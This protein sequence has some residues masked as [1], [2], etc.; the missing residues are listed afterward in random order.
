MTTLPAA[1]RRAFYA[2]LLAALVLP[3]AALA[4]SDDS[5]AIRALLQERD[6]EIKALLGTRDTFTD[7]QREQL[8]SVVNDAIDFRAMSREALGEHWTPLTAQ[9]KDEFVDVFSQ[10]VRSQSLSNLDVYRA[11]VTYDTITVEGDEAHVTTTTV[12][13]EVPTRVEYDLARDGETWTVRDIS[14][15]GVSTVEGY[16]R[17]FQNVIRKRG[18]DTLMT[19]LNRRLARTQG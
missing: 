17:S 18:F 11:R 19:S 6:R 13:Q 10:I 14:L 5:A 1:L 2:F 4:Q 16:A 15:D 8:K 3:S 9:Q 7:E 12:Y